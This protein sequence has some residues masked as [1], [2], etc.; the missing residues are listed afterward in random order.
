[1]HRAAAGPVLL[2]LKE[3]GPPCNGPF[4]PPRRGAVHNDGPARRSC[5]FRPLGGGCCPGSARAGGPC[6]RWA[7]ADGVAGGRT[8]DEPGLQHYCL[9]SNYCQVLTSGDMIGFIAANLREDYPVGIGVYEGA[10]NGHALTVYA[11]DTSSMEPAEVRALRPEDD[12]GGFASGDP[13]LE[14]RRD[15]YPRGPT[16]RPAC[17]RADLRAA[18]FDPRFRGLGRFQRRHTRQTER[19]FLPTNQPTPRPKKKPRTAVPTA[20]APT[21]TASPPWNS[22]R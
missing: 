12:R 6:Y 8:F 5:G 18:G 14:H 3:A 19:H 21:R 17:A 15:R 1:V 10:T 20:V 7:Y 13:D 16:R 22:T 2:S 4:W 9:P 11:I